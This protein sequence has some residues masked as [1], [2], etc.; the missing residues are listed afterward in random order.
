MEEAAGV[1]IHEISF[2]KFVNLA[3]VMCDFSR[4]EKQTGDFNATTKNYVPGQ[5]GG[6][7]RLRSN[8]FREPAW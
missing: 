2:I 3:N 1:N 7:K 6:N 8:K 4:V 5:L